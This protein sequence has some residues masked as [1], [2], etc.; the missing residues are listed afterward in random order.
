MIQ[1]VYDPQSLNRYSFERNNPLKYTDPSG[2][3]LAP[4]TVGY[5]NALGFMVASMG[6]TLGITL[7]VIGIIVLG[8]MIISSVLARK[9]LFAEKP[10]SR[11]KSLIILKILM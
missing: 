4:L 10:N 7:V 11:Q 1:N 5:G 6:A 3:N 8:T 2:H 9:V